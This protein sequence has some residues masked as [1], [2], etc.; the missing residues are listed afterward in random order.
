MKKPSFGDDMAFGRA[1]RYSSGKGEYTR[2]I[3]KD[4]KST[5][6]H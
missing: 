6:P 3:P 4:G 5:A 1:V 2:Y